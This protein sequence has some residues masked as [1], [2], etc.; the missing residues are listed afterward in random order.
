M[1]NI[2]LNG[3]TAAAVFVPALILFV[4]GLIMI[5]SALFFGGREEYTAVSAPEASVGE[6]ESAG[7][8][9]TEY[10][11]IREGDDGKIAVYLEDGK[12][13]SGTDIYVISLP[14]RDRAML[15]AGIM[16]KGEEELEVFLEGLGA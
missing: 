1:K 16:A 2:N 6:E 10:Y 3:K 15:R 11:I 14:E 12:L 13:Y 7:L 4:S 8:E 5:L 9:I